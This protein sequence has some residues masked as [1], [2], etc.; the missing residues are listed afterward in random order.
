MT[1]LEFQTSSQLK[2]L[3]EEIARQTLLVKEHKSTLE[4]ANACNGE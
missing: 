3:V 2:Y 4:E 1:N